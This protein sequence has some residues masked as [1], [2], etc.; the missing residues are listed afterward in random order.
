[1]SEE[2]RFRRLTDDDAKRSQVAEGVP[3]DNG[4]EGLDKRQTMRTVQAPDPRRRPDQKAHSTQGYDDDERPAESTNALSYF[5]D[6]GSPEEIDEECEPS[7]RGQHAAE[8]WTAGEVTLHNQQ[9]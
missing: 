6:T 7:D 1:M 3:G 8:C 9:S 4:F 5:S 2:Y